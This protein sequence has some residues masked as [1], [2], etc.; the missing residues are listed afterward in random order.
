MGASE[1]GAAR[2][3]ARPSALAPCI[4]LL[5]GWGRYP[6]VV[7]E[8]LRRQ[9]RRTFCLGVA[10]QADAALAGVC[11][12]FQ[13]IGLAR[14]GGVI[15]YFKR[16]GIT[17]VTMAGKIHKKTL[18]QR[19]RWLRL[20]PDLR[21]LRACAS[22]FL[23]RRKDCRDDSL[24]NMVADVLA[25][26]GIQLT[27]ATEFAPE[28]LAEPGQRTRRGPSPWQW[29]DVRFG[30]RIAKELGRL[31]LGQA[32]A[33]KDQ[34]VLALEAMEGT[35]A[36]IRR[37]GELCQVGNFVV[38]KVAKPRQD[39][40]FDVPTIGLGTLEAMVEA[41]A[42][43]LAFEAGRTIV[44]EEPRLIDFANRHK[45]VVVALEDCAMEPPGR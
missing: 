4:G 14:L 17:Q 43:V 41:R 21:T 10:G 42:R 16:H 15:R 38:V 30:W 24:L 31:D 33:V 11:D 22:H 32:V 40:R 39:M 35:D 28:L 26:D 12:D 3:V 34:A 36:C 44:L 1:P 7:A 23:T 6:F 20:L 27:P 2:D 5:A 8:A 9:G 45:L 37:A 18:F 25:A 13:W 19:W 29:R